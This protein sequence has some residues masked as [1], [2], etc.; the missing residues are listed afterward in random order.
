M[1]YVKK[2]QKKSGIYYSLE[3][4]ISKDG[5]WQK[6]R[7][8]LGTKIP[9]NLDEIKS[10]FFRELYEEIWFNKLDLIQENF[11]EDTRG[12]PQVEIKKRMEKF[13][14]RFTYNSNRIEGNKLKLR[15]TQ[16]LLGDNISP[17]NKPMKDIMETRAH[18]KLFYDMLEYEDPLNKEIILKWIL[19]KV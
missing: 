19:V 17:D 4:S 3:H 6:L 16:L 14:I 2:L 18:H 8:N 10:K 1:V 5:K 12:L 11:F 15:D 7:K 9:P 13:S